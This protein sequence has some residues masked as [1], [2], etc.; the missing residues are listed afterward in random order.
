MNRISGMIEVTEN[1]PNA[2]K[3]KELDIKF[4]ANFDLVV[5]ALQN[6]S[7]SLSEAL[8]KA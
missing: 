4:S 8:R 7:T 2:S 1:S 6:V 3:D 5:K